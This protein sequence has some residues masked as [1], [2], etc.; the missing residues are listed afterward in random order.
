MEKNTYEKGIFT[1]SNQ[2]MRVLNSTINLANIDNMDIFKYDRHS[3]F[4]GLKTKDCD[5]FC[6]HI[7]FL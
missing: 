3:I 5:F 4:S 1:I 7:N 2:T 6:V